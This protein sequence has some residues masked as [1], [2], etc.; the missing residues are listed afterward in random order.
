MTTCNTRSARGLLQ[1]NPATSILSLLGTMVLVVTPTAAHPPSLINDF[2]ENVKEV[3]D[4]WKVSSGKP[5]YLM[6]WS[7]SQ[8]GK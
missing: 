8:Y 3:L 2:L 7:L 1:V 5:N 6:E 4:K